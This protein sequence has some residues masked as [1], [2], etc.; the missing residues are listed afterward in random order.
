MAKLLTEEQV[1]A[2]L[3]DLRGWTLKGN[4]IR[5]TFTFETFPLALEFVNEVADE[6]EKA[7]HHPDI[8]IRWN[9]V[10]L[11]LSTHSDGGLTE[12]DTAMA[13]VIEGIAGG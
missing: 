2:A 5:K 4:E 10:T 11:S 13:K 7:N 12:K 8:D 1:R 3:A 6:A 9:K